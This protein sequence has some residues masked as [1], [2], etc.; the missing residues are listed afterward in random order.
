LIDRDYIELWQK[1]T[2]QWYIE[3][4][5][6]RQKVNRPIA[7]SAGKR[8]IEITLMV[9]CEDGG[10]ALKHPLPMDYTKTKKQSANDATKMIPEPVKE[11]H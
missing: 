7:R 10:A 6:P 3:Q 4:G 9:H 1:P 8:R 5:S 2:E 11:I